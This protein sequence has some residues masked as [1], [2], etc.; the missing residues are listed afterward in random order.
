MHALVGGQGL[1]HGRRR[2]LHTAAGIDFIHALPVDLDALDLDLQ[3]V[4]AYRLCQRGRGDG[5]QHQQAEE[6]S[7]HAT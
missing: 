3:L 6:E 2:R 1:P 5:A 7:L 4:Q